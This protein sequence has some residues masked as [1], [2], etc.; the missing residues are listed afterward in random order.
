MRTVVHWKIL[1]L[2]VGLAA[3]CSQPL[4]AQDSVY[5][6]WPSVEETGFD[7]GLREQVFHRLEKMMLRP[8]APLRSAAP[9]ENSKGPGWPALDQAGAFMRQQRFAEASQAAVKALNIARRAGDKRLEMKALGLTG[10]ICRDV[11][12]GASLQAVPYH[13]EALAL[14]RELKDTVFTVRQLLALA[15]NYG[16]AGRNDR[17]LAYLDSAA[18]LLLGFELPDERM[19]LG[20]QFAIFSAETGRP[21]QAE[22]LFRQALQIGQA[23]RDT[24]TVENLYW[25][26][27][28]L[29]LSAGA[30]NRAAAALDSAAAIAQLSEEELYEAKYQ[31]EKLRGNREQAFQY[32]EKAYRKIGTDYMRRNADQLVRWETQLR[33][34]EQELQLESQ[35]VLLEAQKR[36]RRLLYSIIALVSLLL[37]GSLY[38]WYAQRK[39]KRALS[40]QHRLIEQQAAELQQLDRLKTRF[41]ANV[42]HEL[43]TPI[44]LILGPIEQ[45]L[46]NKGL[47]A[48]AARALQTAHRNAQQLLTFVQEILD[49]SRLQSAGA[50]LREQATRL[51]DFLEE[52]VQNFQPLAESRQIELAFDY[53]AAPDWT[54]E[55]DRDKLLKILNNLLGNAL[56]FT[57]AGGRIVL[58]AEQQTDELLLSVRD[59]GPGIHSADLPHIFDLYYQSKYPEAKIEGGTGIGLALARELAQLMGGQLRAESAWGEGSIFYLALPVRECSADSAAPIIPGSRHTRPGFSPAPTSERPAPGPEGPQLL[60][61]EDN[62]DLREF[63]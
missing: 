26:L 19:R 49:L 39:S 25:Q 50:E 48:G 60:V 41:F 8:A 47:N 22:V 14:A 58:R 1:F 11:F 10:A 32:L 51:V 29:H 12:L 42:S 15:D 13:E 44:T 9:K 24:A 40:R 30:A 35:R 63:L 45:V 56:K 5:T 17:F 54:L 34:R 6:H 61:V 33:T 43:R 7:E 27:F 23:L 38:A 55:L 59:T 53:H 52:T 21:Q 46:K 28:S 57:P 18:Q 62:G 20:I 4:A 3:C 36:T 16:Q 37:V 2:R 31:L